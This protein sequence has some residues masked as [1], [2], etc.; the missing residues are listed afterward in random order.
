MTQNLR[1]PNNPK[2]KV[3]WILRYASRHVRSFV[4][5]SRFEVALTIKTTVL[6]V[7]VVGHPRIWQFFCFCFVFSYLENFE[8]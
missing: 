8:K 5:Y 4:A 3:L 7:F 1:K 2:T 6:A